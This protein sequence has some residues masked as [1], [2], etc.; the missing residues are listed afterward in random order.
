MVFAGEGSRHEVDGCVDIGG[1]LGEG[2]GDWD[3]NLATSSAGLELG[4]KRAFCSW[5][6]AQ[7]SVKAPSTDQVGLRSFFF[8]FGV[9]VWS[10]V[11]GISQEAKSPVGGLLDNL[12]P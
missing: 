4:Y 9:C 7:V 12:P 2:A 10:C 1:H 11:Y 8:F 6:R 5:E 3:G